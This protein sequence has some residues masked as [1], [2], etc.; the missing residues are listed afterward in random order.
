METEEK[1]GVGWTGRHPDTKNQKAISS[2]WVYCIKCDAAGNPVHY[3]ARLVARGFS[4]VYGLDYDKTYAPV[5]CL[6]TIRLLL[7]IATQKDWEI[8]QIDVKS[9]YLN[10][11]L[12][13][14]I[15]MEVP[16][17]YSFPKGCILQLRKALYRL[18]QAG[19]QWYKTL[20]NKLRH[21]D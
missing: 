12:D 13:E 10:G 5:T 20:Q 16:P 9:T 8:R 14:D 6:E 17:G 18:R 4:Q 21:L 19:Q 3:K 11:D 15:Y 2:K 1:A 7:G